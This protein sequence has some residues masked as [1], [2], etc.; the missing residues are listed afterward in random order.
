MARF[1]VTNVEGMR[2][3]RM[4]LDE[5]TVQAARGALSNFRGDISFTPR[6]PGVGDIFRNIFARESRIRPYYS[7]T[8]TI[9]LQP[10]LAGFHVF[11]VEPD[12]KWILEPGEYWASEGSVKL[13]LHRDPML[14]SW[15]AGDGLFA[16]KTTLRGAGKVAINAPGPVEEIAVTDGE[17]KVQGR[18]VLGRTSG[19]KFRSVRSAR[20]PRNLIS[21]QTRLRLFEGT[22][23][24]LVSW[25]PY[26][27]EYLHNQ[28]SGGDHIQG[29]LFE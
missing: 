8:G 16:W 10:S 6:L 11:D 21:G 5:E 3:L 2:Q 22:G 1:D 19:L 23:K 7:G 28:M 4:H 17:L 13:G 25:T 18:L 27:N 29:S 20:F 12:E 15:W 9:H 24:A 14:A 26:W